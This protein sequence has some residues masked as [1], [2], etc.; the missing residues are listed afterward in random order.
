MGSTST[1]AGAS[2]KTPTVEVDMGD[3]TVVPVEIL[4]AAKGS[5][6]DV[7]LKMDGYSWTINGKDIKAANLK[8]I[9]LEVELNA[10]AIP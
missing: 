2:V 6:I 5:D 3:A 4:E 10:N 8:E 1:G 9:N 7:V